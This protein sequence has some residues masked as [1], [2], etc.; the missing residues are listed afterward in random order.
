M[1][2]Q[3]KLSTEAKVVDVNIMRMWIQEFK[4]PPQLLLRIITGNSY[5]CSPMFKTF[6]PPLGRS[7]S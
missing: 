5:F 7:E 2:Y 4:I 3:Y 6:K 1:Y